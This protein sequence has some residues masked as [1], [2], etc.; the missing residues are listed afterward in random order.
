[1][2]RKES[3]SLFTSKKRAR[4]VQDS[5]NDQDDAMDLDPDEHAKNKGMMGLISRSV[6]VQKTAGSGGRRASWSVASM[7]MDK[8]QPLGA[9]PTSL[10][11]STNTMP[12]LLR[13]RTS[14]KPPAFPPK[15]SSESAAAE[16]NRPATRDPPSKLAGLPFDTYKLAGRNTVPASDLPTSPVDKPVTVDKGKAPVKHRQVPPGMAQAFASIHILILLKHLKPRTILLH[17]SR[18]PSLST[19]K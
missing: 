15:R 9:S 4:Y 13:K 3:E 6:S 14:M 12:E 10:S 18:N 17:L 19:Q 2:K 5:P 7:T 8:K 11:T 16:S 1:M